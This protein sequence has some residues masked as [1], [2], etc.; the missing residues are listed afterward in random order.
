MYVVF[1]ERNNLILTRWSK[2]MLVHSKCIRA[3]LVRMRTSVWKKPVKQLTN[4]TDGLTRKERRTDK[5][6][7]DTFVTCN[8]VAYI[9]VTW[10]I[11]HYYYWLLSHNY[12]SLS[13]TMNDYS[14]IYI[15][16]NIVLVTR[17]STIHRNHLWNH[18]MHVIDVQYCPG[19]KYNINALFTHLSPASNVFISSIERGYLQHRTQLSPASNTFISGFERIYSNVKCS[20]L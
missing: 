7:C 16:V 18:C 5:K 4:R 17:S 6:E 1:L 8:V 2:Y 13:M 3:A 9:N 11:S 20:Y 15:Y 14:T 19:A 10:H 12:C